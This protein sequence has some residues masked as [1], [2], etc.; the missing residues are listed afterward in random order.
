MALKQPIPIPIIKDDIISDS[1]HK[2][3]QLDREKQKFL[4][5]HI[6]VVDFL[7]PYFKKSSD[8]LKYPLERCLETHSPAFFKIS[9]LCT[10]CSTFF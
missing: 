8:K 3:Q 2:V 9:R 10:R 7:E 6:G 5:S 4:L 1:I